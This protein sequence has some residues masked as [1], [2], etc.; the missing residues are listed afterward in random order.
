M[1]FP[2]IH[3][4]VCP[5]SSPLTPVLRDVMSAL[6]R[7]FN[8]TDLSF[9]IVRRFSRSEVKGQV[10]DQTECCNGRG[11]RFD[12][13]ASRL[14]CLFLEIAALYKYLFFF[15]LVLIIIVIII[16]VSALCMAEVLTYVQAFIS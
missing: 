16:I 10:R 6:C 9:S 4:A 2:V 5:L 12:C 3:L 14:T 8:T 13:V 11:K 7:D 15:A 1:C